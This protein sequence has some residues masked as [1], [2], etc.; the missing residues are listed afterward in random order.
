M[1]HHGKRSTLGNAESPG[2]V[3][4][5]G[6]HDDV[7]ALT[8]FVLFCLPLL[9]LAAGPAGAA[10]DQQPDPATVIEQMGMP[11]LDVDG[12]VVARDF[13]FR[14]GPATV[15]FEDGVL[16]PARPVGERPVEFV[17]VGS[18]RFVVE[19]LSGIPQKA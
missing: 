13:R 16:V 17:F 15:Y 4:E 6:E 1:T 12:A 2:P 19:P 5:G 14:S 3:N 9:A 11:G 18:G 7:R 10:S 8:R